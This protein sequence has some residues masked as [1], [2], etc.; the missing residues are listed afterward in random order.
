MAE[1]DRDPVSVQFDD[2]ARRLLQRAYANPGQWTGT[3]LARP[4]P[5]WRAWARYRGIDLESRDRWGEVR[6]V[7]AFK[8]SCYW[9]LAWY[10]YAGHLGAARRVSKSDGKAMLWE[11]GNLVRKQ[12]WPGRRYAIRIKLV[13]GG[14]A[15]E[16]HTRHELPPAQRYTVSDAARS[17]IADRDW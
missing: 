11:T 17:T 13:P 14:R 6:W 5:V 1:F 16:N 15:A 10:G 8:R 7:R 12:G 2:A 4:N 9:N 3:Y